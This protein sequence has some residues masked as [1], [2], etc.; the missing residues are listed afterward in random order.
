METIKSLFCGLLIT[1][2]FSVSAFANN[3]GGDEC[4]DQN[5]DLPKV[6]LIGEYAE[7]F[8]TASSEYR[9]Q[10][11]EACNN[12]MEKAFNAWVGM[13]TE[14][15]DYA[16]Q[17]DID[18]KGVKM[19]VKIFWNED[20][21][22]A[23]IAYYLKPHSKNIDVDELTAFLMSFMN[24]YSFPVESAEKFSHYGS[25]SFPTLYRAPVGN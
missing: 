24:R 18:I 3:G 25:A 5:A 23:H 8:E 1:T 19:W 15:E 21:Q 14:M 11:M 4:E 12:D 16:E 20:G 6:F 2:L 10:L 17:L 9:L 7:E 22:I 13:L